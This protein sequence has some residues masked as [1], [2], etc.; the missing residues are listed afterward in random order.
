MV[1]QYGITLAETST[2]A[3][4]SAR[5]EEIFHDAHPGADAKFI[6]MLVGMVD[7]LLSGR[8]AR[9]GAIDMAYHNIE[10]TFQTALCLGR[11]YAGRAEVPGLDPMQPDDF[12]R[13]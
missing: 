5:L 4:L 12:R 10:H 7:R 13:A 9:Y 3:R 6:P 8:D 2:P 11:M 1:H